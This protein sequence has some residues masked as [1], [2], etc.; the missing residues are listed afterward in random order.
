[1]AWNEPN[2]NKDK[3]PKDPWNKEGDQWGKGGDQQ[4]PPD[5][6][7]VVRNLKAKLGGLF[8]GRGGGGTP[9]GGRPALGRGGGAMGI[10]L[11]VLI[12]AVVWLL[13]GIYIVDPA[14]RGVV[15]RFGRYVTT[16]EPGPHWHIPYPIEQ[17]EL[18]DVSQIR[19]Y[20]IGYRSTGRG[21]AG[22]PVPTEALMLTQDENIVDVRIA[23]QYRVKDAANYVFNV[24]NADINL[25]QVVESSLREVVGKNGMDFVLTEGR[26][27]IM[28]QTEKLAQQI[29]DQY[30]AGLIV[31]SVNMQDA[32][33]PEQ[34]QAAFA[35]AI[36]AREDQQRLRNEAEAYANDI[37]PK[38]RGAAFR[39]LQ[40][41]EAYKN[42]V[43]AHSEGE[44]ARFAQVL[45]EYQ[46]APD[47]TQER[48]YLEAMESVMERSRKVMVDVPEGTNVFYLPLDRMAQE[49]SSKAQRVISLDR[50]SPFGDGALDS[51]GRMRQNSADESRSRRS[52]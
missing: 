45:K 10:T 23:V 44:T 18:V 7:E 22:S 37:L 40:E 39:K 38:A 21:R 50:L 31:T 34:V 17:V 51:E 24:R 27:E 25:R 36:K 9:G 48:L 29:L 20:E 43:V 41:A 33:P 46:E 11:L 8:G 30:N 26:T 28:L 12:L 42:E 1:M 5:L 19:S 49:E 3:E 15:L 6:D 32:Q 52:R 2:E 14:E 47:I 4:G 16:T 13:S 35:D